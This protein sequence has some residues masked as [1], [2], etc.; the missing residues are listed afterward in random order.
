MDIKHFD[1][2]TQYPP[3]SHSVVCVTGMSVTYDTLCS[4]GR[5][6]VVLGVLPS[7]DHILTLY[8]VCCSGRG[9]GGGGCQPS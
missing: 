9:G 7:A 2:N 6:V 8:R 3:S 4:S 5:Y 1:A